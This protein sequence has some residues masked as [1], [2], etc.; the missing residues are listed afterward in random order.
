MFLFA[1]IFGVFTSSS[2]A[3]GEYSEAQIL[4]M[5][6][7]CENALSGHACLQMAETTMC[8]VGFNEKTAY[9]VD[10]SC[11]AFLNAC[12]K[13]DVSECVGYGNCLFS[14]SGIISETTL[15]QNDTGLTSCHLNFN[16][17]T[18]ED[19]KR[20]VQREA[21]TFLSKQCELK[22]SELCVLAG[23]N[24]LLIEK[25]KPKAK[26]SSAATEAIPFLITACDLENAEGCALLSKVLLTEH[27]TAKEKACLLSQS[28]S[29][30]IRY[31][32]LKGLCQTEEK[33]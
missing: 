21:V 22:R 5:T 19:N 3:G 4:E 32:Y 7:A 23:E 18:E 1:V 16:D 8:G 6:N 26:R 28:E 12:E 10:K 24:H 13:G 29:L 15:A 30:S 20:S 33:R 25:E 2:R 11:A 31:G 27:A 17:G 9:W 14:C